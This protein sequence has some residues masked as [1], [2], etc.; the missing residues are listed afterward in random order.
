MFDSKKFAK[1]IGI[2]IIVI[3]IVGY[4][5]Y[6]TKNMIYGPV[7]VISY[8]SSGMTMKDS[9]VEVRGFV[10]NASYITMND[11]QIF[12]DEEGNFKEKI[13]LSD[14]YNVIEL[15]IKDKFEREKTEILELMYLT[16]NVLNKKNH[17]I[18]Q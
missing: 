14:G 10:K 3:V 15:S 13:L 1:I 7:L 9:L 16:K 4:S 2:I 6:Q 8:P 12:V 18:A 11:N 5:F 17:T